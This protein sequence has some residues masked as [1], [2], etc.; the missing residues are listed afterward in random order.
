MTLCKRREGRG[1]DPA[2]KY[3]DEEGH[4]GEAAWKNTIVEDQDDEKM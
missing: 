1:D 3:G 4:R 2:W